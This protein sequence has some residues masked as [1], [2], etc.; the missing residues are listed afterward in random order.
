MK[1]DILKFCIEKG[2]LLDKETLN[3]LSGFDEDEA[4]ELIEKLSNLKE[5]IITK[6][7][8]NKNAEKISE[9]IKNNKI[10]EKLKINFGLSFEISRERFVEK[11]KEEV[12]LEEDKETSLDHLKVIYSL[13]NSTRKLEVGDFVKY[14]RM[15]YHEMKLVLQDRKELEALTSINKI[16]TQRQGLSII[17]M[18]FDK[19]VT[20]N[21]NILLEL[22]DLTGRVVVLVNKNKIDVYDKAKEVLVDDVVGIRGF[23]NGEIIF[24]NEIVYPEAS[25]HEKSKVDRDERAVFISDIHI[26]SANFLEENFA[27]FIKWLNGEMGDEKQREE[28]LKVKYLFITGDCVDGV[29]IFPGQE[30]LLDIKDIKAQYDKL[31]SY[32]SK[33]RKDIKIVICPGQHDA[34]RVAEPQPPINEDYAPALYGLDN[35]LL[36]SNP[37]I[38]EIS[39]GEK[40]RG[41]RILMY[42]G[43]NMIRYV[44]EIESLRLGSAPDNPSKVVKELL[45]RRHL[46]SIHSAV[47]YI[48][49][50]KAD[51]L[52][53]REVPDIINTGD[54]HHV[55]VD[56]YNNIL[57]VCSSCWQSTTPFEEKVGNHPDPCKVP[58]LNLKT[59]E[60]KILDFSEE[61]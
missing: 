60:I 52:M 15:R 31:A 57:I 24:A 44:N 47:V 19:R 14:F 30:A 61:K 53:I 8:F 39:N 7:F 33:L 49:D 42:H 11:K 9:L 20:K 4:R 27:K 55:D 23:G 29:G 41:L 16:N 18:V 54:L 46:A 5:K 58:V 2:V 35:V 43:A 48:P 22:E 40:G 17:G 37:A 13:A 38:I 32:L 10:I 26:G 36:V 6:S 3:S 56:I 50:E 45:K 59:R 21:K 34:V 28:A 51:P 1:E 25:L 12:R